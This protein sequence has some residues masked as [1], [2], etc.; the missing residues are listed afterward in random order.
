VFEH[1]CGQ[2]V[3]DVGRALLLGLGDCSVERLERF[4]V[5]RLERFAHHRRQQLLLATK[6]PV[7]RRRSDGDDLGDVAHA[8]TGVALAGEQV[9]RRAD[10]QLPTVHRAGA[11]RRADHVSLCRTGRH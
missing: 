10:D 9:C 6:M 11:A 3:D 7:Q 4:A 2:R 1:T 5:E 8:D